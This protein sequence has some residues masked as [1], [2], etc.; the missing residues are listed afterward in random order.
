MAW[1]LPETI[2]KDEDLSKVDDEF[3][4]FYHDNMHIFW[5]KVEDGFRGTGFNWGFEEIYLK[6]REAVFEMLKR[7]L[8]H[9]QPIN[10]LDKVPLIHKKKEL[11]EEMRNLRKE[12]KK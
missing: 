6:H 12:V 7:K 8:I 4:F 10:N 9:L 3:L 11:K 1:T 2:E 5:K